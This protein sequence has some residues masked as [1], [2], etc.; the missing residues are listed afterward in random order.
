MSARWLNRMSLAHILLSAATIWHPSMGKSTF[1][2]TVGSR[3]NIMKLHVVQE[4]GEM[5]WEDRHPP[6]QVTAKWASAM[7]PEIAPYP[8]TFGFI[9]LWLCFCRWY[10]TSRYLGISLMYL[11]MAKQISVP[12]LD[13]VRSCELA[14]APLGHDLGD[15]GKHL[16]K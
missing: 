10:H 4:E 1:V 9:S 12:F 7:D 15:S 8:W 2:A 13:L 5:F 11:V 6:R 14:L 16:F 3:K